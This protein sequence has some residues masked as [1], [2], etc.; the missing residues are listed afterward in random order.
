MNNIAKY[1]NSGD[2]GARQEKFGLYDGGDDD[3]YN[4]VGFVEISS[5]L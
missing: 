3:E 1:A 5:K 2:N 4:G